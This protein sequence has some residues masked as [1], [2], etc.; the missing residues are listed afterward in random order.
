MLLH[1]AHQFR[2]PAAGLH[3]AFGISSPVFLRDVAADLRPEFLRMAQNDQLGEFSQRP[4][5]FRQ[6]DAVHKAVIAA[7][8]AD[9][10]GHRHGKGFAGRKEGIHPGVIHRKIGSKFAYTGSAQ[11]FVM[12]ED[13]PVI[14]VRPIL[15]A[16]GIHIAEPVEPIRPTADDPQDLPVGIGVI[17][18]FLRKDGQQH[19]LFHA[20][21]IVHGKQLLRGGKGVTSGAQKI[22]LFDGMDM[23]IDLFHAR[24]SFR[25]GTVLP[26]S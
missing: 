10:N 20:K 6:A 18:A 7:Q 3:R 8:I 11:R 22:R 9:V 25:I 17:A 23:N 19:R 1:V 12:A 16:A 14:R 24:R 5:Q 13:L 15:S 2:D 21:L 26:V 4:L